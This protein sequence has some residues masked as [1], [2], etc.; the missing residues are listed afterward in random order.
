MFTDEYLT[1]L[2]VEMQKVLLPDVSIEV[3][4]FDA[5][6][7]VGV[8]GIIEKIYAFEASP[9]VF[10]N[11][12]DY[13]KKINYI[14]LAISDT[15]GFVD[16]EIQKEFDP[17]LVGHNSI[18]KRNEKKAYDYLSID[19]VSIDEYFKD[20]DFKTAS[21]WI[22][23]EGAN[24]EVLQGAVDTIKKAKSIFIEVEGTDH[25]KDIWLHKDVV[26]FLLPLGFKMVE[27]R[28]FDPLQANCIFIKEEHMEQIS[29][30]FSIN[31]KAINNPY[32]I[33]E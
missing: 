4:A 16:F 1:K 7:S 30:I 26:N 33:F 25:W 23:C 27:Y 5:D 14:N 17:A 19:S 15:P 2:Y 29:N 22:D 6:Y 24:K 10:N 32:E 31:Q 11:F 28:T 20:I 12:K 18:K 9:F 8:I 13:L 3:G 21:L